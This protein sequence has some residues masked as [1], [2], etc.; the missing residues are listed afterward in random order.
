VVR[1]VVKS[2]GLVLN[3]SRQTLH[4]L[5]SALEGT[6]G[7][8]VFPGVFVGVLNGAQSTLQAL[9]RI[10]CVGGSGS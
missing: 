10:G 5:E 2:A 8:R 6:S 3:V 9:K 7:N 1:R 4:L